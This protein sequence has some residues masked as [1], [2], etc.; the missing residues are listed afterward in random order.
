MNTLLPELNSSF[1]GN[2]ISM[3]WCV[4]F[5]LLKRSVNDLIPIADHDEA[6]AER[7]QDAVDLELAT[8]LGAVDQRLHQVT[9]DRPVDGERDRCH[10]H[11]RQ[12]RAQPG[13]G[14][15]PERGKRAGHQDLAV[16]EIHDSRDT[17]LKLQSH[18][19]QR[20]GTAQQQSG[21]DDGHEVCERMAEVNPRR[22]RRAR[23]GGVIV[24]LPARLG[25]DRLGGVRRCQ[26]PRHHHQR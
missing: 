5:I 19:D 13:A 8:A 3:R 15:E 25:L 4:S 12:E 21:D 14:V 11:D 6:E 24:G 23:A 17:V 1:N 16:G 10:H 20:I 7:R 18:R 2:T 22:G 9:V 26:R